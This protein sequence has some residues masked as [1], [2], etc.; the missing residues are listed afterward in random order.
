MSETY[1]R[2][3]L[4]ELLEF[5][6]SLAERA[7]EQGAGPDVLVQTRM[8]QATALTHALLAIHAELRRGN[9]QRDR[10]AEQIVLVLRDAKDTP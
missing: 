10:W 9:D 8:V 5:T 7:D 1:R 2:A 6:E 3:A 4:N